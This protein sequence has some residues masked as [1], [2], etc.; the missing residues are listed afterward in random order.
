MQ[1]GFGAKDL[2]QA[3]IDVCEGGISNFRLLYPDSL[4]SPPPSFRRLPPPP[5]PP[6]PLPPPRASSHRLGS[7]KEKIAKIA[8]TI[9]GAKDVE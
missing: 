5:P 3:V 4:R 2:A 1:G 6:R 7:I 8:T 9:Y